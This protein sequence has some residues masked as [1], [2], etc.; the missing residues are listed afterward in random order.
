MSKKIKRWW[1]G[2]YRANEEDLV[3]L[4]GLFT[5]FFIFASVFACY[6]VLWLAM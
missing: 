1:R 4:A 5:G 6:F 2:Y 3:I